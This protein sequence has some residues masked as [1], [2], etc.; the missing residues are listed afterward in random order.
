MNR[1]QKVN[2]A[3]VLVAG[4]ASAGFAQAEE[5]GSG[6]YMPGS[7][8]S[9]IDSVPTAPTFITRLNVINY[10]GSVSPRIAL[11]FGG[12]LATGVADSITGVGVP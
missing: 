12:L 1:T 8:A 10:E 6:H 4:L 3:V 2:R 7:M 9:F 5:G 11:P